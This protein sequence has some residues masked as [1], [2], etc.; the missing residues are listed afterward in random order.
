MIS[1]RDIIF[2]SSIDWNY[3]W[4]VHQEI[5]L[6]FAN[7]NNRVIYIENT[8]IRRPGLVDTGRVALRLKRWVT[9]QRSHG[10][11]RV[12][13]NVYVISPLMLPPF[14]PAWMRLINRRA[15]SLP[16][17]RTLAR[18]GVRDPIIWT[19][20]PTDTSIDLIEQLGRPRSTLV[21][22]CAADF[23]QLTPHADLLRAA[24]EIVVKRSDLVFANSL[25]LAEHCRR[26]KDEVHIFPPGVDMDKFPLHGSGHSDAA[27]NL[28]RE[29]AAHA[30]NKSAA[31]SW[32]RPVIGY[33]GGLH[34]F[35]DYDMLIESARARPD[36][37]WVF[38]GAVQAPVERLAALPNV[39]MAGPKPHQ[40]LAY[41]IG[42]F[43][44]CLIPY[45]VNTSTATV[46]PVKLNEYLAVGKP[47]VST[48]LPTV[49]A[50]NREHKILCTVN[51]DPEQFISAIEH[52]LKQPKDAQTIESRRKVAALNDWQVRFDAM[53]ELL[54]GVIKA[55]AKA[56]NT[57]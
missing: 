36:W 30:T 48:K 39:F 56:S 1:G 51:N 13:P 10:V 54:S 22:Y 8:G 21:Y 6:R 33:V 32:P 57:A 9:S 37:S 55:S 2:I 11:R 25:Q 43:D 44:V 40:E 20:L 34:R 45:L 28:G 16:L 52:A 15:L 46:A 35:V 53:N 23:S 3:L 38:V 41:Y 12:A 17:K 4:Q 7:T 26:W 50:F 18:L 42:V 14:G 29:A 27:L 49:C 31:R 24:E 47:V 5:A 19:Y